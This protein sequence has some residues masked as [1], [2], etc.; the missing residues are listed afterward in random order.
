MVLDPRMDAFA[1]ALDLTFWDAY[2]LQAASCGELL[3]VCFFVSV[4]Y[5]VLWL[6]VLLTPLSFQVP[7]KIAYFSLKAGDSSVTAYYPY[8]C[9][10]A[11]RRIRLT[12]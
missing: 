4:L 5:S 10:A 3:V 11:A 9:G 6:W 12:L 8:C 7:L 1:V 2:H